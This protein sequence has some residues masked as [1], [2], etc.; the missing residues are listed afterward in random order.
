MP[1]SGLPQ[2][3]FRRRNQSQLLQLANGRRNVKAPRN[4]AQGIAKTGRLLCTTAILAW[5]AGGSIASDA[6]ITIQAE[7][8]P[9]MERWYGHR[10]LRPPVPPPPRTIIP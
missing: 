2:T 1:R 5:S 7:Q 6:Q 4:V 9:Q 8:S 3:N 10:R